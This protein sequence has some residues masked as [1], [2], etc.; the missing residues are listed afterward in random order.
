V[1]CVWLI[2]SALWLTALSPAGALCAPN[3][4]VITISSAEGSL[5]PDGK[6]W[7]SGTIDLDERWDILFPGRGGQARY[8]VALPPHSGSEPMAVFFSRVGNQVQV[9]IN[10]STVERWGTLG[11][12]A[13]DAAKNGV[14]AI[15]PAALLRDDEPNELEVDVTIQAQRWGGLSVLRYG[16]EF[17]IQAMYDEQRLWRHSAMVVFAASLAGM[18]G[19]AL[20]LWW[21]QRD[22]LYGWFALAAFLGMV[23]NVDRVWPDVPV[24][25]PLWGAIVAVCYATHLALICRFTLMALGSVSREVNRMIDAVLVLSPTL[26]VLSFALGRP[27]FWTLGLALLVPLGLAALTVVVREAIRTRSMIACVLAAAGTLAVAAGIYD[28]GL[29]RVPNSSGLRNAYTQHAMFVF[30]VIMAGLVAERYSRSVADYRA[31]NTDLS[32]RVEDREQQLRG[33]FDSLREQQHEQSV[34][35]ERQRIMR[36]IHDGIGSHLVGLLNMVARPNADMAAVQE[37]VQH[38]LDEMRMAVDSLQPVHDDLITVLATLRYRLQPRLQA[39]GVEVVW[40][41]SE[42]PVLRHL[43]PNAV[44][45]VQRILLEAFTNVLKHAHATQVAVRTRWHEAERRVSLQIAD[46][47]IG[48]RR[49]AAS[50]APRQGRGIGNMRARAS[51]IGAELTVE[52]AKGGGTCLTLDWRVDGDSSGQPAAA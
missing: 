37:Q 45:Q 27:L 26:A 42:L 4:E 3:A 12:P 5:E 47:G 52:P 10:G 6:P 30:V 13:Y 46:N 19:L 34:S 8:R 9:Q 50:A 16:P 2:A 51:A 40:D 31:L 23:R 49:D 44:L 21:R 38:A 14:M 35:T 41:V 22:P 48:L 33:A 29:I 24:P 28:F 43:S 25:W 1:R 17:A 15:L 11:D 39:A 18:G 7:R 36:E 20:M 32:Q